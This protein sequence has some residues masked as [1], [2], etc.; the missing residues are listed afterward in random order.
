MKSL[1]N[2]V[3]YNHSFISLNIIAQNHFIK[4][5]WFYSSIYPLIQGSLKKVAH[6]SCNG[7]AKP[8]LSAIVIVIFFFSWFHFH[9]FFYHWLLNPLE[10]NY[11][12]KNYHKISHGVTG[13][14]KGAELMTSLHLA[15]ESALSDLDITTYKIVYIIYSILL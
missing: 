1:K 6:T 4:V 5:V 3:Y 12:E 8:S 11:T 7:W 13:S 9:K 2:K 14:D 10:R 15:N